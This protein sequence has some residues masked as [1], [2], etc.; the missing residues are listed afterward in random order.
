MLVVWAAL[1]FGWLAHSRAY[2]S[3]LVCAVGR[4]WLDGSCACARHTTR[5]WRSERCK[6]RSMCWAFV[7][8]VGVVVV[9]YCG[10]WRRLSLRSAGFE[11]WLRLG[12]R[13][14]SAFVWALALVGRSFEVVTVVVVVVWTAKS[15]QL[16]R[17]GRY[18]R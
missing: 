6:A 1:V 4:V 18:P 13:F 2:C 17:L 3:W 9:A 11:S 10:S 5:R 7:D 14:C 12:K 8:V 15:L 16:S